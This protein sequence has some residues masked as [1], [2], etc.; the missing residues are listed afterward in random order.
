MVRKNKQVNKH[1]SNNN[2][3]ILIL[4]KIIKDNFHHNKVKFIVKKA[5]IKIYNHNLII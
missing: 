2:N 5:I 1:S 4:S 3:H